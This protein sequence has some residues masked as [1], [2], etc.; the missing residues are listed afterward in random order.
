VD[1]LTAGNRLTSEIPWALLVG[2]AAGVPGLGPPLASVGASVGRCQVCG[3]V[4]RTEHVAFY[5]NLGMIIMRRTYRI[6]GDM[7][8]SCIHKKYWE[9]TG[10]N[11]LLGW[12]GMISLIMTPIYF[13][14]NLV[15]YVGALYKLR[16]AS[17]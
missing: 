8:R 7:C 11:L 17:I 12:W 4:G 2:M 15:A 10:L 1:I 16:D 9:F 13:V 5:R 6:E 3:S 14:Q